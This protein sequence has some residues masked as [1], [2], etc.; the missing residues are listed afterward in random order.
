MKIYAILIIALFLVAGCSSSAY[1]KEKLEALANCLADKGVKEYGAFWCPNC[2][3]QK[4]L[5]GESYSIIMSRQVYVECDPRGDNEQSELCIE[6]KIE[7][8][9]T[10]EFTNEEIVV[11]IIQ[12]PDLAVKAGCTF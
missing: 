12:L 4:K 3:N 11:G 6:K 10:W 1:P 2:A 5:F 7:K 9:P 8:Y